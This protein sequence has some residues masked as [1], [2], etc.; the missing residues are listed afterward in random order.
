MN[1]LFEAVGITIM[2]LLFIA[3][4]PI[5]ILM[6]TMILIYL[7]MNSAIALFVGAIIALFIIIT[8]EVYRLI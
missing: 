2:A 7:G 3:V 5:T 6:I 4:F 1:K 8:I